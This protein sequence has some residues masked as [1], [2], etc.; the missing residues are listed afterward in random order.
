[1]AGDATSS[2]R[3]AIARALAAAALFG[4]S[5]PAAKWLLAATDAWLLAGLL[6]LGSG[7]GLGCLWFA[8]RALGG[9]P[10]EAPLRRADLPWLAGAVVSGGGVAPVLLMFGLADGSASQAALL[11]NLEGVLTALLA[12]FVFGEHFDR[13]IA[14]GMALITAGAIV[15]AWPSGGAVHVD[16]SALLVVGACL[17]WAVDNNLTRRLSGG[18]PMLIAALKG[19]AAGA[20][21]LVLAAALGAGFPRPASVLGAA[22]VGFF[23]Y[24]ISLV[25]FIRALRDLGAARTG[26]YFSTAPFIGAGVAVAAL[27][28]PWTV[29]LVA[30]GAAMALGA[31]V[32]VSEHHEHEHGHEPLEHEHRHRHDIHHEHADGTL[33][34]APHSHPHVQAPLIHSHPHY[35]DLHHRHGHR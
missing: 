19:A 4:V 3:N 9:A 30:G 35:P 7:V 6:Y 22:V 27:G 29:R 8:G 16:G 34:D 11:L 10:E 12:W 5:T 24:G 28:D 25:L 14:A 31:W 20:V 13:R 2:G 15:L 21:N 17:A 1:M 26:A 32:H 23:G 18:D 33:A